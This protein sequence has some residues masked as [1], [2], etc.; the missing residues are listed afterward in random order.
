[1]PLTLR[2]YRDYSTSQEAATLTTC[3]PRHPWCDSQTTAKT[4]IMAYYGLFDDGLVDHAGTGFTVTEPSFQRAAS[5]FQHKSYDP[6]LNKPP[7]FDDYDANSPRGWESRQVEMLSLRSPT[8]RRGRLTANGSCLGYAA[9][10]STT[11]TTGTSLRPVE[12]A[13]APIWELTPAGQLAV[14]GTDVCVAVVA[15]LDPSAAVVLAPC[16]PATPATTFA[17]W[18]TKQIRTAG[19]RCLSMTGAIAAAPCTNP[20]DTD[21]RS[22]RH[23]QGIPSVDQAWTLID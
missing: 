14:P 11:L 13:S 5:A 16:T 3:P 2:E 22:H 8:A 19:A 1:L 17:L 4:Q 18:D 10:D 9:L 20:R 6:T 21:P 7:T 23:A 12:C 15:S